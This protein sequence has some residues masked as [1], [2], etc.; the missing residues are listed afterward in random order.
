VCVTGFFVKLLKIFKIKVLLVL[1]EIIVLIN[2]LLRLSWIN[3]V[4]HWVF[5]RSVQDFL[6]QSGFFAVRDLCFDKC[7]LAVFL[8][9][10]CESLGFGLNT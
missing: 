9:K 8:D 7:T 6:N 5:G 4:S 2:V 3:N 1:F 10:W